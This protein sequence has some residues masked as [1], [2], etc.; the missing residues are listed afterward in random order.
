MRKKCMTFTGFVALML[1]MIAAQAEVKSVTHG[2]LYGKQIISP[3]KPD[4]ILKDSIKDAVEILDRM[5]G[6]K[7]TELTGGDDK[8]GIVLVRLGDAHL[9]SNMSEKLN[10]LK[11]NSQSFLIWSAAPS[12]MVIVSSGDLGLSYGLYYYMEK[13]GCRWYLPNE[14]FTIIPKRNDIAIQVDEVVSPEFR[15]RSYFAT[16]GYGNPTAVDPKRSMN[17]QQEDWYRRNRWGGDINI[18][19]HDWDSFIERNRAVFKQHPEYLSFYKGKRQPLYEKTD[20]AFYGMKICVSNPEVVNLYVADRMKYLKERKVNIVTVEASDGG[21][22]CE[23]EN[24]M[25][26]GDG[27]ESDRFFY[28]VNE[29]AK[30][31]G[32]ALPGAG[33]FCLAYFTHANPPSFD[34]EPNVFVQVTPEGFQKTRYTAGQLLNAWGRKLHQRNLGTYEYWK[35]TDSNRDMPGFDYLR[36]PEK[37]LTLWKKQGITAFTLQTTT[38]AGAMGIPL[39]LSSKLA[40]NVNSDTGAILSEFYSTCF[41]AAAVPMK[42]LLKRWS[43]NFELIP[44]V[45]GTSF[46]DMR[47]AI[48]LAEKEP[49]D[50]KRRVNDFA[51]YLQYVRL[52]YEYRNKPAGNEERSRKARAAVN[53][54]WRTYYASMMQTFCLDEQIRGYDEKDA[55]W[56]NDFDLKDMSKPGWLEVMKEGQ[57]SPSETLAW[58]EQGVKDFGAKAEETASFSDDLV[59]LTPWKAPQIIEFQPPL[60]IQTYFWTRVAIWIPEGV[61]EMKFKARALDTSKVAVQQSPPI[62]FKWCEGVDNDDARGALQEGELTP[63]TK[64]YVV[65]V[66]RAG[67]HELDFLSMS[68]LPFEVELPKL[69]SAILRMTNY[70]VKTM[71]LYFYVPENQTSVTIV[72]GGLPDPRYYRMKVVKPNGSDA[73]YVYNG[74]NNVNSFKI[75]VGKNE[76]G[77]WCIENYSSRG[78]LK[79][80]NAPPTIGLSPDTMLVPREVVEKDKMG[81]GSAKP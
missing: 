52:Y 53:L 3:D 57:V 46:I 58:V 28:L 71:K 62:R 63:E 35:L 54:I 70:H 29:V 77:V 76:N 31:V 14:D 25:K 55:S 81:C 47:E 37:S 34:L 23:C 27:S 48:K 21:G 64:V 51:N 60:Q 18:G 13:L 43:T 79:F 40:W 56:K 33:V 24:C 80:R 26:I 49:E 45:L 2:G 69:P 32:K 72:T 66:A 38:G 8:A 41:G 22:F 75:N 17:K 68:S 9:P 59:P 30:G 16:G 11:D 61:R 78:Q 67:L 19:G 20:K 7:F 5:T 15:Y 4:K 1:V 44:E 12:K 74:I 65:P 73:E 42:R 10:L 39:Y 6:E 50:V 36:T